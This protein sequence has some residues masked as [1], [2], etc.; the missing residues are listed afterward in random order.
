VHIVIAGGGTGG[1]LFPGI[2]IAAEFLKRDPQSRVIF[3]GTKRGIEHRL[4]GPLGYELKEIDVEGLK[5]RGLTALIKGV[6]AIPNSMWQSRRLLKAF[7]PDVVIGVGGYASG[8]AVMA[9]YLMGIPTAIAEQNAL[10][11]NTNRLLGKFVDKIFVTYEQSKNLFAADKVLVT[12]NPVRRAFAAGLDQAKEKKP[13]R[14]ILIF[15]GSQG[16]AAIN[17]TVVAMLPLLQKMKDSIRIVHQTGERDLEMVRQA[18][19]Q[20]G[21]DA[22]VSPFIVDMASAYTASDLII[23]RAGATSLAEITAAGKASILIPF[24]W[25]ANDH[26]TLNAQVMVETGAA[27]M[28]RESELTAEKLFALMETLLADDQ[29]LRDMGANSKKSGRL[30]AAAKIVDTC[31]QLV[32]K[33]KG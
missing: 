7:Q 5:G 16:A 31:M 15:G 10:A 19:A 25:A 27:A 30:D 17:K 20:H 26:Q 2:A 3:I 14:R 18:Y 23:C 11:G 6:Y 4:L 13:G 29:K 24:P 8:P 33:K 21:L 32:A 22:E 28:I 12:G 9:A 1:H